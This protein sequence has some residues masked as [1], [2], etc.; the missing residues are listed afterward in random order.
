MKNTASRKDVEELQNWLKLMLKDV[1][2]KINWNDA[3]EIFDN[4]Q[5]ILGACIK[6]IIRQISI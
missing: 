6:E 2:K 3:L 1:S 4:V 5:V